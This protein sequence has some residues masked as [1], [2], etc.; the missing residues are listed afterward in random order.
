MSIF[1][2]MRL[3]LPSLLV[4]VLAGG[5][6]L[7]AVSEAD[8]AQ[9]RTELS[10]QI[11]EKQVNLNHVWTM[12]AACLVFLMQ[13]GFLFLEAGMVRSKNSISVAQ[14]NIVDFV[15]AT[16]CFYLIGFGLMFGPS[17]GGW[18]GLGEIAFNVRAPWDY[19]FFVFQLV[20]CGTAATILSGAVAERMKFDGYLIATVLIAIVVYPVFGHWAWGNL[21][22]SD[23]KPWLAGLGFIDF[24]GSTVVHSVGGWVALAAIIV[25]GPRI[26]RFDENGKALPITG[27]SAVLATMGAILLW[28]GWVG[29][30]GGST[31]AGTPEFAHIISNTIISGGFGGI[32]AMFVGRLADGIY[33]PVWPIN[34]ILAGLVGITAGCDAVDTHGAVIIG[35]SSG[36]IVFL[37]SYFLENVLKLDDAVGAVPVHGACGAWGT[38]MTGVLAVPEKLATADRLSQILAQCVGVGTGFVWAFGTSFIIFKVIHATLGLRVSAA[39]ELEGLNSAEHGTTLGTGMLQKALQE[40]ALGD[41][42]MGRR[43]DS[44]TGDEAGE[45]A[46]SFN[47]L[48]DRLEKLVAGVADNAGRLIAA[49]RELGS[50]SNDLTDYSSAVKNQAETVT[51]STASV[52]NNVNA[53]AGSVSGVNTSVQSISD[54]AGVVLDHVAGVSQEI[55]QM[56]DSMSE[57]VASAL[58][59]SEVSEQARVRVGS[60]TTTMNVLGEASQRIGEIIE[61]IRDIAGKTRM[62]ALNAT[63]EAARAGEAGRGFAVVAEE[64]KR[65]ADETAAATEGIEQRIGEIRGGSDDAVAAITDISAVI[66]SMN[67]T[68]AEIS[69]RANNQIELAHGIS[70]S[71]T[72]A[73]ARSDAMVGEIAAVAASAVAASDEAQNAAQGTQDV[74]SSISLVSDAAGRTNQRVGTVRRTSE[75]VGRI[76]VEL[77]SAIGKLARREA[78]G[79]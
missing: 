74:Y 32:V 61:V 72:S 12:T 21:L 42:D 48:M 77:E 37:A 13:G 55:A 35:A 69:S 43:L 25:I 6:A 15:I 10:A 26:G 22:V 79:R 53:M 56:T 49:S 66:G 39:H 65:L 70:D 58:H 46:M 76:A 47:L 19:T 59:A 60:A 62:L 44:S 8:L 29:F 17:W 63:I 16:C 11:A 34:G 68:I 40:L 36:V 20:F 67:E 73:H 1:A 5:D 64:V 18:I 14:K 75:E 30:N 2:V 23:N 3:A 24:A 41:G 7:A 28:V 52:L 9:L 33:R 27:H 31:T 45:L 57:I 50:V 78:G 54:G 4:L 71:M 51:H 38:I